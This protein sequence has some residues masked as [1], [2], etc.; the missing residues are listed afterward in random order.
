LQSEAW[1]WTVPIILVN[2]LIRWARRLTKYN[3][4]F[5]VPARQGKT[6]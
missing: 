4:G 6:A 5:F 1:A 3:T 2:Q